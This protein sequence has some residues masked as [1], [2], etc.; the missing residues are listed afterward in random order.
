MSNEFI[1]AINQGFSLILETCRI[2]AP[3]LSQMALPIGL[4]G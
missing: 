2:A 3:K 4:V 1:N